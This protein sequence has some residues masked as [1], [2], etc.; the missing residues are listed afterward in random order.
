MPRAEIRNSKIRDKTKPKHIVARERTKCGC[1]ITAREGQTLLDRI[2][3]HLKNRPQC[4]RRVR[5]EEARLR[6]RNGKA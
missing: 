5:R 1:V 2:G 4:A 3:F 6:G